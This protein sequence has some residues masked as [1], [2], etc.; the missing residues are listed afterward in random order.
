MKY[1]VDEYS[2]KMQL[3]QNLRDPLIVF[4]IF[5]R[6]FVVGGTWHDRESIILLIARTAIYRLS[7]KKKKKKK[8]N[9]TATKIRYVV[10]HNKIKTYHLLCMFMLFISLMTQNVLHR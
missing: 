9:E 10:D 7:N 8:G 2:F 4:V 1:S 3:N 5:L 6:I